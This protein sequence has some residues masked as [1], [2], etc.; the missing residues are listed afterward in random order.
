MSEYDPYDAPG[1]DEG[2]SQADLDD[3][4]E[5]GAD[6]VPCPACGM[7]VYED[8]DRCPS[9][10]NWVTLRHGGARRRGGLWWLVVLA[11]IAAMLVAYG[12]F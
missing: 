5:D 7:E 4:C 1:D 10:G 3:L 12:I 8:A 6:T 2:P 11:A 9:C